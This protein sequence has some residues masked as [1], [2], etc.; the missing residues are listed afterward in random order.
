MSNPFRAILSIAA[1]GLNA[2]DLATRELW[3][4]E[5]ASSCAEAA[6]LM[7]E[8][9]F[10]VA[11][12]ADERLWRFVRRATL[13][14]AA[15]HAPVTAVAQ[16]IDP[17]YLVTADLG[18]A[19][20]LD[21]L[22][23]Q[24]DP[25][26]SSA[27]EPPRPFLFVIEGGAVVGIITCADLQRIPV[28]MLVLSMILAIEL[29]FNELI[30]RAYG[31]DGFLDQLTPD[32]HRRALRR[33]KRL[34]E[35]NVD[36]RL[37]DV[38]DFADRAFLIGRVDHYRDQLNSTMPEPFERLTECLRGLR[39]SLAHGQ[40]LLDHEPDPVKALSLIHQVRAFGE[41]VWD[42]VDRTGDETGDEA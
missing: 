7:N 30:R 19:D 32:C 42:L 24:K 14:S 18:L 3:C 35:R 33:Y 2:G 16:A 31:D 5:T 23:R 37:V 38:L 29:G 15:P 6:R 25:E 9:G 20:T 12:L 1:N 41:A 10:D 13:E 8:R 34:K 27:A 11:P 40:T 36:G 22:R 4:I 28:T 21:Y 26:F 17:K 39:N